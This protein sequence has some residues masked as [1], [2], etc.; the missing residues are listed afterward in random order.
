MLKLQL[1]LNAG[2]SAGGA[3]GRTSRPGSAAGSGQQAAKWSGLEEDPSFRMYMA[4]IQVRQPTCALNYVHQPRAEH[5]QSS[6]QLHAGLPR[7]SLLAHA[8]VACPLIT[9]VIQGLR[10]LAV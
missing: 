1:L 4:L 2:P 6:W 5:A 9:Q 3:N 10:P 7:M 8:H